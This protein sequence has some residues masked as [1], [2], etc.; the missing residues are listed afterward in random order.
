[1]NEFDKFEAKEGESLEYVY[2][3][4]STFVNVMDRNDVRPIKVS[5]KTKFL[6]SLQ[7]DWRKYV[8]L[9]R[10]NKNLSDLKYD[11]LYDDLLQFEPYV[12]AYK[13][14][15]TAK[16]HDILPLIAHS[17]AYLRL[18]KGDKLT[19][20]MMLLARVI[21]QK[22][23]TPTNNHLYT[24][25]NTKNQV[26]IH[27]GRVDI[28]TKNAGYGRNGN[29]NAGRQ[30]RNQAA[31]AGNSQMLIA[32]KDEVGGTLNDEE[33]DFMLDNAHGDETLEEL[34]AAVI[35]TSQIQP[36][37]E[38]AESKPKYDAEA[39]SAV[40]ASYIDLISGMISKGVHEHTN[41]EK[42]KIVIN[43]YDDDQI[44]SNII[45]DDPYVENNGRILKH[46][47]N[48]HDQ[49]FN[50][51]SLVYNVQREAANQQRLNI[52]LKKQKELL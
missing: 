11:A 18:S 6:N 50:I 14:K 32:M 45:F 29:R 41:H 37:D 34:T 49:S 20:E 2:E 8:T 40:N 21:T 31:N 43:T 1:M 13:V 3:R 42:L 51:E 48:A 10:Q 39:I 52:E 22:F 15:T 7:P 36:A 4:L 35:M 47:L 44:D 17:N 12:Q 9:T 5:I 16:N 46:A 26:V 33:N 38:N 19:T 24:S 28:Q 30:K 23:S 27:D 25:S